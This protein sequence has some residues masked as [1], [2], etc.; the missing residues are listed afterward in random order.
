MAGRFEAAHASKANVHQN[1][2][3][4]KFSR[5]L[6]CLQP[7][8]GCA[9]DFEVGL[10]FQNPSDQMLPRQEIIYDEN[11]HDR[12]SFVKLLAVSTPPTIACS[13]LD[14]FALEQALD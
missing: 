1:Y 2:V 14:H 10:R 6:N 5:L 9:Y 13:G 11:L 3:R 4:L 12:H 7:M 8:G